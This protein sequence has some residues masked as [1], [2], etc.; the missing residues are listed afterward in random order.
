MITGSGMPS[1]NRSIRTGKGA[2][3]LLDEHGLGIDLIE[4]AVAVIVA[5]AAIQPVMLAKIVRNL[6]IIPAIP[7]VRRI[8]LAGLL[9]PLRH[10][11]RHASVMLLR[12]AGRAMAVVVAPRMR[13]V[14][15]VLGNR[16]SGGDGKCG[17]GQKN[18][19]RH[20]GF[21]FRVIP[22]AAPTN[23]SDAG[24]AA[25]HLRARNRPVAPLC[26]PV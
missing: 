8:A 14:M 1:P 2:Q 9:V 7:I 17:A 21:P 20:W 13:P 22:L 24:F 18:K 23:G 26:R 12:Q 19:P 25:V 10:S 11:G 16:R 15:V 4:V 3:H 6:R 5:I